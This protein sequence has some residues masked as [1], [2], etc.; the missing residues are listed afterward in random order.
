MYLA[1]AIVIACSG[2]L[3]TE[4]KLLYPSY[5]HHF[6]ETEVGEEGI[7]KRVG[8]IT[9]INALLEFKEYETVVVS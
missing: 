5:H 8:E 9:Q 6:E 2:G 4:K 1:C 3:G 7:Q